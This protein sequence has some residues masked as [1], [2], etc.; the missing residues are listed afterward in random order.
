MTNPSS[1]VRVHSR[2]GGRASVLEA[3]MPYQLYGN[4]ILSGTGVVPSSGLTVTVG[5]TSS[6]PDILVAENASGYKVALDVIGITNLTLTKPSSNSKIV[7]IV[8]YT[9][10]LSVDSTEPTVTGSPASCG[11]IAVNGTVASNPVAPNDSKI[12]TEISND[13]GTGSQAAYAIIANITISS[14]TSSITTSLI[15]NKKAISGLLD[16][17]YPVGA[18]YETSDTSFDPNISWG[19][20]WAEDS[21]GRVLVAKD[22]STFSTVGSTGGSE[23]HH[24]EFGLQLPTHYGSGGWED[25]DTGMLYYDSDNNPSLGAK[26]NVA[27]SANDFNAGAISSAASQSSAV[28]RFYGGTKYDTT[29]QPY[30]VIKR[31]H[32]TA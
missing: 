8:A 23:K 7:S 6:S 17:F 12:R 5:G 16:I 32:R 27:T 24:H 20:T 9:N 19:G 14:S 28:R 18:Y 29:L 1:I 2:K 25:N 10:D 13:G 15:K 26:E 3:N 30:V 22:N 4:G 21:S 31:W 11:L